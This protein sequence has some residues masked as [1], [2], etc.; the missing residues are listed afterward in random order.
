MKHADELA[1]GTLVGARRWPYSHAHPGCWL[2]P[3]R[4]VLLARNDPRAWAFTLFS[5]NGEPL[6]DEIDRHVQRCLAEGLLADVVPVL[7]DFREHG[8][9]VHWEQLA[10]VVPAG[11]DRDNWQRARQRESRRLGRQRRARA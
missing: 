4:G 5:P 6:P 3:Y 9:H 8:Q 2:E 7:W 11:V 1:P 10:G